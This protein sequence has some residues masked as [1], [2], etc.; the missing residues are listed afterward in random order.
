MKRFWTL[1]LVGGVALFF[2]APL[3][4]F[5]ERPSL[6]WLLDS[7][8][9]ELLSSSGESAL[10]TICS[11]QFSSA[12]PYKTAA[13]AQNAQSW[14]NIRVND[15]SIDIPEQTTQSE[16]TI[17]L[18]KDTVLVAFVDT[19]QYLPATVG[20]SSLS[21]YARSEDGGRTFTDL[22]RVPPSPR[23][24]G[25]S[26]PSLGVDSQGNFYF[27]NIQFVPAQRSTLSFLG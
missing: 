27:S 7:P 22:G 13:E 2:L 18:Y 17:A 24:L 26:D 14:K 19:G 15:P 16:T 5:A 21:G 9:R 23:S 10:I 4:S 8:W 1:L 11:P 20:V 12:L 3:T 6:C 25:Y